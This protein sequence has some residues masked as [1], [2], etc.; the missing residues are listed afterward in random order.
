[1]KVYSASEAVRPALKRT[2]DYLFLGF[3]LETF[4]KLAT[5]ATISE[6]FIVSFRFYV[7][8]TLP[9][10]VNWAALKLFLMTPAYLPL[11]I[12]GAA[13]IFLSGVYCIYVVTHLRFGFIHCLI[14]Q[15]RDLRAA[16]KLYSIE[17]ERFF[18]VFML[19][20]L[21]FLVA[22][23]LLAVAVIVAAYT[24]LD[25]RTSD[26]NLDPGHLLTLF[27]PCFAIALILI[28]AMC[29]AQVV[30][31]DFILP[32]MAIE[33]APVQRAWA[34]VRAHIAANKEL[35]LSFFILRMCMPLVAGT[36]L[37]FLAWV[38]GLI[39]FGI[40]GI[41]A[42]G[43]TAMLNGAGDAR[44]FVLVGIQSLFLLL[45]LG[46]G[47]VIAVSFSGP[48]GVFMRSYALYFY[49]GHYKALGNLLEPA[50]TPIAL[51]E[52]RAKNA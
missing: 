52:R 50:A 33:G 44:A 48:V 9:F 34:A 40:L 23:S 10:D 35:F 12:L 25:T 39:V 27:V 4:L 43:F 21:C 20:C 15:T 13:A 7:A 28:V 46:A 17:A 24:V 18:T 41:S 31:N 22:V 16:S 47:F 30:L 29:A 11:T 1:M 3:Q 26:G 36:V 14:H 42:A 32:H 2:Y 8:G 6:G 5:V 49:G 37:G 38:A 45:G 51:V 19:V